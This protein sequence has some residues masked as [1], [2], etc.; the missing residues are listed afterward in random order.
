[1]F[2]ETRYQHCQHW[3]YRGVGS[4]SFLA[5]VA[6]NWKFLKITK[7][8]FPANLKAPRSF[9]CR[10]FR[11]QFSI[12]T[13]TLYRVPVC[14]WQRPIT[15][16]SGC[17]FLQGRKFQYE[18]ETTAKTRHTVWTNQGSG[19]R[20]FWFSKMSL[21]HSSIRLVTTPRATTGT[22]PALRAWG[23]GVVWSGHVPDV[24]GWVVQ[25]ARQIENNFSLSLFL[26]S[27]SFLARLTWWRRTP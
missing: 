17:E 22:I 6:E 7:Y 10:Y 11:Q 23:W 2:L 12:I 18:L 27:T 13:Q 21:M 19:K 8:T 26:W 16:S 20:G 4:V 14:S 3:P 5:R 25:V 9:N 24:R 1:M 15:S